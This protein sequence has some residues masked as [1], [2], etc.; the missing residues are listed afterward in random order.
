MK[1]TEE[2]HPNMGDSSEDS[3]DEDIDTLTER[4]E[5]GMSQENLSLIKKKMKQKKEHY[6]Q[7]RSTPPVFPP[8]VRE[9][10]FIM[11]KKRR[12]KI[13]PKPKRTIYC[14]IPLLS[15]GSSKYLKRVRCLC[16]NCQMSLYCH[17]FMVRY[18]T[19]E[20]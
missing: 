14:R 17:F 11:D 8:I 12:T 7:S 3:V 10:T 15:R 6:A 13:K 1:L 9:R 4:Q 2:P 19:C 18:C 20:C 5:N 16:I